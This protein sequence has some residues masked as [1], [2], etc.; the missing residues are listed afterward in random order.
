[1]AEIAESRFKPVDARGVVEDTVRGLLQ[2]RLIE[3]IEDVL[4]TWHRRLEHGY[5]IPGV[6]RDEALAVVLPELEEYG[7]YSRGRFGAWKY[8][9][10]NQDHSFAQGREVVDRL[11]GQVNADSG[12]EPTLNRPS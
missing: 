3:S 9:V 8:E 12:P 4:C 6:K 5:P 11:L 10:S 2:T 1:M 7:I